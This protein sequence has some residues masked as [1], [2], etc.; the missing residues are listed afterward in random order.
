MKEKI[1]L[2]HT[3]DVLMRYAL[4]TVLLI[5]AT[6]NTACAYSVSDLPAGWGIDPNQIQGTLLPAYAGTPPGADPNTWIMDVGDFVR[7]GTTNGW[8]ASLHW[9]STGTS[10]SLQLNQHIDTGKSTN[11]ILDAWVR[12]GVNYK[13]FEAWSW[14]TRKGVVKKQVYTVVVIGVAPDDAFPIVE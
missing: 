12:P 4:L 14:P 2:W 10:D 7:D 6:T 1:I 8:V 11:W 13:T 9:I 5:A 3:E